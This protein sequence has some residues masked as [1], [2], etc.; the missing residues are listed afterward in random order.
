MTTSED[1]G[2]VHA[3]LEIMS[4]N[5]CYSHSKYEQTRKDLNPFMSFATMCTLVHVAKL[6]RK[7]N[8]TEDMKGHDMILLSP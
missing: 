4:C 5:S 1:D 7:G 6:D 3:M 2:D 8:N